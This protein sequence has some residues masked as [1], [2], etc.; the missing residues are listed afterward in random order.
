MGRFIYYIVN[1]VET[2]SGLDRWWL[3]VGD[4]DPRSTDL[5]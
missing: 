5:L 3:Y 4:E 2:A 1:C